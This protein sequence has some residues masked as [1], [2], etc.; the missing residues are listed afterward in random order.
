MLVLLGKYSYES[1]KHIII[2]IPEKQFD[3]WKMVAGK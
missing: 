1:R 3:E 2:N